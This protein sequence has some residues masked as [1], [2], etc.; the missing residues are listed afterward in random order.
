MPEIEFSSPAAMGAAFSP[1]SQV[2][3][4]KASEL[5]FIA[6]QVATDSQGLT[7]GKGDFEAQCQQ[8]L[9]NIAI[10]LRSQGADWSSVV[11][12]TSYLVDAGDIPRFHE[13]RVRV[14]PTMFPGGRYPTNTLLIVSRLVKPD[15][16]VEI[17]ATAAL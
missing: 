5:L 14:F 7:V 4:V 2:A 15:F 1:Y 3:R 17:Q 11:Q 9:D 16:L 10:A 13:F 12:F 6:G 8:A